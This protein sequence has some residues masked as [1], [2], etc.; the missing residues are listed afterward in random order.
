MPRIAG[1]CAVLLR[2]R[3]CGSGCQPR[4]ILQ[5]GSWVE[6]DKIGILPPAQPCG[7]VLWL[8][9]QKLIL[10]AYR[11][12]VPQ[13]WKT[14]TEYPRSYPK[15]GHPRR[16]DDFWRCEVTRVEISETGSA[17]SRTQ[18]E[19]LQRPNKCDPEHDL[20]SLT[21]KLCGS[22]KFGEGR[23]HLNWSYGLT[24]VLVSTGL[25]SSMIR[26]W[27]RRDILLWHFPYL[28]LDILALVSQLV[29]RTKGLLVRYT[30]PSP[31]VQSRLLVSCS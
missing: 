22:Q 9:A 8:N 16:S 28:D 19:A 21:R 24:C 25:E 14:Q 1:S 4:S 12:A 6:V 30:L 2:P 7:N 31:L 27:V 26:S 20:I 13:I 5:A 23:R 17:R 3:S 15:I 10:L 29:A 11:I 18:P